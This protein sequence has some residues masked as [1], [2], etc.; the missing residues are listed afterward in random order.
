MAALTQDYFYTELL[1]K[2]FEENMANTLA[3]KLNVDIEVLRRMFH[4]RRL[5]YILKNGAVKT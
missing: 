2:G 4:K 3:N 1:K 5:I